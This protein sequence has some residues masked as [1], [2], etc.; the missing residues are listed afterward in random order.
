[1]YIWYTG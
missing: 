1:M